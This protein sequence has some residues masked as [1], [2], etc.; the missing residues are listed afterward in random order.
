VSYIFLVVAIVWVIQFGLA[1]WQL[2]RFHRR[3]G[4][5]RRYGRT[6][7]GMSGNRWRGRAYGVLT[8]DAQGTIRR[9]EVFAGMT[10]FSQLRPVAAL[11]GRPLSTVAADAPAPGGISATHWAAFAQAAQFL[12]NAPT[13][14]AQP[15]V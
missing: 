15:A 3:I 6:S 13:S 5:L 9:A 11:E 2:Q 14:Q 1:Y 12:R 4:E 8:V 7:V 10:V